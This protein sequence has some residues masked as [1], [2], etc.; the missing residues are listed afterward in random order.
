MYDVWSYESKLSTPIRHTFYWCSKLHLAHK[1]AINIKNIW[2]YIMFFMF[3][4]V[5]IFRVAHRA[6][7][8][9]SDKAVESLLS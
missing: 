9:H 1:R 8:L 7:A 4:A 5:Y 6:T 2:L 3:I